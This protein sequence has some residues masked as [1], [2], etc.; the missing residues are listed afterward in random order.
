MKRILFLIIVL[1]CL[2]G[3]SLLAQESIDKTYHGRIK[4]DQVQKKKQAKGGS[5]ESIILDYRMSLQ[6]VELRSTQQLRVIPLLI[7]TDDRDTLRLAEYLIAGSNRNKTIKRDLALN[8]QSEYAKISHIL[9]IKGRTNQE[10]SVR[11]VIPF[12]KWMAAARFEIR[13]EVT[14]C[15]GCEVGLNA[16]PILSRFLPEE[17]RPSYLAEFVSPKVEEVKHRAENLEAFFNYKQGRYELLKDFGQNASELK[18]VDG[19]VQE[20]LKDK[21]LNVSDYKIDGY[22]SPEGNFNQNIKLSQNRAYTFANYMKSTYKISDSK[23]KTAWHGEDWEGLEKLVEESSLSNKIQILDIIEN[24]QTDLKREAAI[25]KLDDGK[26]MNLLLGQYYPKLRRNVLSVSYV[27][28]AFDL[29]EALVIYK[30]KPHLLS[31]EELFRVANSYP[32]GSAEFVDVFRTA[33]KYFPNDQ[34]ANLNAGAAELQNKNYVKAEDYLR[35]ANSSPEALNNLGCALAG[36]EK[37]EDAYVVFDR[38]IAAGDKNAAT[39]KREAMMTE[40]TKL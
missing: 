35:K 16:V 27:V 17:H 1:P 38:A 6:D 34:V 23:I 20:I 36:Q 40:E 22:A 12:E 11:H 32:S 30:T 19:F 39:N 7:S 28:K 29:D 13:E 21:N 14:G 10:I 24:E 26:T 37:Y 5:T 8:K 25:H 3:T 4:Y 31:L 15:A 18:R 9:N 2:V 33:I